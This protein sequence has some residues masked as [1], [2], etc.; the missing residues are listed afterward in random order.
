MF[1]DS[2]SS[3]STGLFG[4]VF[5]AFEDH[6][7][8]PVPSL[9]LRMP[10]SLSTSKTPEWSLS[11]A[12]LLATQTTVLGRLKNPASKV[13]FVETRVSFS[14]LPSLRGCVGVMM[15]NVEDMVI[16]ERNKMHRT[17]PNISKL[18]I[19]FGTKRKR[20]NYFGDN[21]YGEIGSDVESL[22]SWK[23]STWQSFR[24]ILG[25]N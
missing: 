5:D 8:V 24:V 4:V 19:V 21:I 22:A 23:F 17:K 9:M 18:F 14:L 16:N 1:P 20:N 12:S 6:T 13:S 2:N 25:D 7:L 10:W 3:T 11:G 15:S